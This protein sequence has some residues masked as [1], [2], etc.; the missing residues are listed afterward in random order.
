[1]KSFEV[2]EQETD[3]WISMD[4]SACYPGIQQEIRGFVVGLR[5]ELSGY[6]RKDPR[7]L[8]SLEPYSLM[9]GAPRIAVDMAAAGEKA[10]VGP[11]AAVAGAVARD[12]GRFIAQKT[13][14]NKL[15]V[16][17]GGDIYIRDDYPLTVAVYAGNSPLSEKVGIRVKVSGELGVCT[18]SGTVGHSLSFGAADAVAVISEDAVTADAFATAYCNQVK[19]RDDISLVLGKAKS[20]PDIKGIVIISGDA[21]G[22]WG[23]LE[24]VNL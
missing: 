22:A 24:L 12:V 21:L 13:G 16:E 17:N 4:A 10:G 3:L 2:V 6:I 5:L 23:D 18:S 1:M 15:V 9:S 19:C 20:C 14:C 7:F 8:E 11:M